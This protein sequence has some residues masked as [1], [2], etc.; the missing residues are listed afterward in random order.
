MATDRNA[1]TV[2]RFDGADPDDLALLGGK[3]AS[4]VRMRALDLPVPPGFIVTTAVCH[5]YL[6]ESGSIPPG[7]WD[8]VVAQV[9]ALE[10]ELGQSFGG[11]GRPLLLSVRSGAPVSMPGMMDTVLDIGLCEATQPAIAAAAGPAFAWDTRSRL[12]RMFGSTVAGIA[13]SVFD[14]AAGLVAGTADSQLALAYLKAFEAETGRVFPDEPWDQLREA[15]EAV[16]RSWDS[17][18]A[19]RYRTYA[20]I[21]DTLGTAVVVQAMVFGNLG[22]SSGTGVAFTRDPVTGAPGVY[23]DFL[24]RAQG[25]DV[26]AGEHDP[27]DV[28]QL[29]RLIPQAHAALLAAAG[30]LERAYSD[31][32]DIEFTVEQGTFWLLQ[33]R[34]G[35]RTAAAAV[36]IALDLV[37]EGILDLD[38]AVDR[39]MPTSML[40]ARDL[41]LDPQAPRTVLGTGLAASPG[42]GCGRVALSALRAEELADEGHPV[43]LVRPH[44]SPDDIAGFIVSRAVVT[45]HGGRTSH[46][47]VV[48]RG[49]DLPAVCGVPG[50]TVT[51]S[52]AT[53]EGVEIREGDEI[54]VDGGTGQ[55]Y[56]GRL[57]FVEPP[58]D[59]RVELLLAHCDA[60]RRLKV[61]TADGSEP[62]ADGSLPEHGTVVCGDKAA[63]EAALDDETVERIVLDPG[64]GDDPTGLIRAVAAAGEVGIDLFVQMDDRW[65]AS[66]RRL[67]DLPWAGVVA[68]HRGDWAARLLAA[69]GPEGKP[70]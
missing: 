69:L 21:S 24:V 36:K 39:I 40:R 68:G 22:D 48:A 34:P 6:A 8:E 49:M 51:A 32:C 10:A 63:I 14:E 13:S 43:V 29:A 59:P 54:T 57:P 67:P 56:A 27:A 26:V 52:L 19:R 58:R 70:V 65:P 30:K 5:R 16:F 4:L 35:Q 45:A 25:E 28:A 15:V 66:L 3:G 33:V 44:T 46:A 18:R 42:A 50:L 37:D 61:L 31:M 41:L 11:R 17:P 1:A 20:G 60:R 55:V 23:G 2:V 38:Q 12:V 64:A 53:F 47:A 9:H 62:W 7:V